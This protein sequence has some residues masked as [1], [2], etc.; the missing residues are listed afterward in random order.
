MSGKSVDVTHIFIQLA[1]DIHC[2]SA[3]ISVKAIHRDYGK[4]DSASDPNAH[5][6]HI[7]LFDNSCCLSNILAATKQ[8]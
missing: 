8:L 6:F 5:P 7:I 3:D 1:P 2:C 4:T